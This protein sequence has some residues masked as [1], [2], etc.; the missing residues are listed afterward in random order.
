MA[1]SLSIYGCR[2]LNNLYTVL[3]GLSLS[4]AARARH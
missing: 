1:A 2:P 4:V 3:W